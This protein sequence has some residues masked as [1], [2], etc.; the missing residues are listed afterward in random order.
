MKLTNVKCVQAAPREKVYKLFDGKGLYLEVNPTGSKYWRMKYSYLGKERLLAIGVFPELSLKE[1]RAK[2]YEARKLLDQNI[3]PVRSKQDERLKL[4]IKHEN[5]FEVWARKWH[6]NF[7]DTWTER[8]A[9]TVIRRLEADVFPAIG[10]LPIADIK[11]SQIIALLRKVEARGAY[12]PAHRLKQHCAKI[13]S[14]AIIHEACETNPATDVGMVLKP[15][16]KGHYAAITSEEL[17]ELLDALRKNHARLVLPQNPA[18][19]CNR[20]A[21]L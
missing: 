18:Q 4:T 3:D 8:H 16:I 6:E 10:S 14:W 7:K 2:C 12:E 5:T 20:R 15:L 9:D 21:A 19:P 13:F 1:A 11:R 17:P